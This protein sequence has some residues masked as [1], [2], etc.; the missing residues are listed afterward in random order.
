MLNNPIK[1]TSIIVELW[2]SNQCEMWKMYL[3]MK[4]DTFLK[5]YLSS[6]KMLKQSHHLQNNNDN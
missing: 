2:L 1:K 6:L 5:V 4:K 3:N